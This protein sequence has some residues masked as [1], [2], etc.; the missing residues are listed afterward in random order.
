MVEAHTSYNVLL[1][2][3]SLNTLGAVVSTPYLAIKFLSALGNI[4]NIHGDQKL[5]RE[6]YIASLRPQKHALAT[7]NVE[8]APDAGATL[9]GEDLDPRI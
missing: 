9:V 3:P 6:S 4:I 2:R 1:G 5:A 7:N 8:R